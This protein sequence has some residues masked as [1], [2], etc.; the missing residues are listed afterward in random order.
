MKVDNEQIAPFCDPFY[1]D[2]CFHGVFQFCCYVFGINAHAGG[3]IGPQ[4]GTYYN[5]QL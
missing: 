1:F 4:R 5:L 2:I 3:E